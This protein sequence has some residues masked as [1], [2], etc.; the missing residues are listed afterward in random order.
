MVICAA[1]SSSS[2]HCRLC[3]EHVGRLPQPRHSLTGDISPNSTFTDIET[4]FRCTPKWQS[5]ELF[6]VYVNIY[7]YS[8]ACMEDHQ[9]PKESG[10]CVWSFSAAAEGM[11][12][13]SC[14]K[15]NIK[16]LGLVSPLGNKQPTKQKPYNNKQNQTRNNKKTNKLWVYSLLMLQK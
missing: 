14:I 16:V 8:S 5:V 9:K 3:A 10:Q 4:G 12:L 1:S 2:P 15:P 6:K 7:V 13:N 11:R